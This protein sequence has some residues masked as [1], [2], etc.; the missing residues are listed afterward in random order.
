MSLVEWASA[1]GLATRAEEGE[2]RNARKPRT[3]NNFQPLTHL[4]DTDGKIISMLFFPLLLGAFPLRL[5]IARLRRTRGMRSSSSYPISERKLRSQS[6]NPP[7]IPTI[8]KW[9]K[10]TTSIKVVTSL[11]LKSWRSCRPCTTSWRIPTWEFR[12]SSFTVSFS[13]IQPT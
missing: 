7:Q 8:Q 10:C 9:A 12:S 1:C 4:I 13:Q 6:W 2:P 3:G 11:L 5:T